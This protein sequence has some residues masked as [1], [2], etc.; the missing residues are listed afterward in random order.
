M[1]NFAVGTVV[2]WFSRLVVLL[3]VQTYYLSPTT[4]LQATNPDNEKKIV[5]NG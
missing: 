4:R 3:F 2:W 1:S 5:I